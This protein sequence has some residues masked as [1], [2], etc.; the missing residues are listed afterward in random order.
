MPLDEIDPWY[1]STMSYSDA[2][3]DLSVSEKTNGV[4]VKETASIP[5]SK[6]KPT[7]KLKTAYA[8]LC[9]KLTV[10]VVNFGISQASR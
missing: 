6:C 8:C 4:R 5:I 1:T 2:E 10:T 9:L 7:R 3:C